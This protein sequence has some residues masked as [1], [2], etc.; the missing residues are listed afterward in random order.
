MRPATFVL[1]VLTTILCVPVSVPGALFVSPSPLAFGEVLAEAAQERQITL[2]NDAEDAWTVHDIGG[3]DPLDSPFSIVF[4]GCSGRTLQ[5][6]QSCRLTI[7]FAPERTIAYSDSF[8]ITPADPREPVL[9]V[10]VSGRGTDSPRAAVLVQDRLG[11]EWDRTL[12][13][14]EVFLGQIVNTT[15]VVRNIGTADLGLPG[16]EPEGEPAPPFFLI[17]DGCSGSILTPGAQCTMVVRFFPLE[18]GLFADSFPLVS[19]DPDEGL[20]T[21]ALNGR[22]ISEAGNA[23]PTPPE[24][25]HPSPDQ[26]N[27]RRSVTFR[28]APSTDPDGDIVGYHLFVSTSPDFT[29]VAPRTIS[30]VRPVRAGGFGLAAVL[31]AGVA[32][33]SSRRRRCALLFLC[34]LSLLVACSDDVEENQSIG[35]GS[36][37]P[38]TTYYWKVT[39]EDGRGGVSESEVRSFSTR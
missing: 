33:P 37:E 2:R 27:L 39:A 23:L 32:V 10:R 7:R 30:P 22:G 36:L 13:F 24:L 35:V 18:G 16:P 28:W 5:P 9:S 34:A 15:L 11:D 29:R 21:I 17:S 31:L 12:T 20:L 8:N 19:D 14:G 38:R 3:T 6:L 25:I 26:D 1:L 4:D